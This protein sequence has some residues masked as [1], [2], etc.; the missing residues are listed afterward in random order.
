M[1]F[2]FVPVGCNEGMPENAEPASTLWPRLCPRLGCVGDAGGDPWFSSL[3]GLST[4]SPCDFPLRWE[5]DSGSVLVGTDERALR[6]SDLPKA[7][8][9]SSS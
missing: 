7:L 2:R 9:Q 3:A 5:G 1:L 4:R 8:R 6:L